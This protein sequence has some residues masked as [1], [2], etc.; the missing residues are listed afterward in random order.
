MKELSDTTA[1]SRRTFCQKHGF[2]WGGYVKYAFERDSQ[3]SNR[4]QAIQIGVVSITLVNG[5]DTSG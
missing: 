1:R 3:A 4:E 5:L 2:A